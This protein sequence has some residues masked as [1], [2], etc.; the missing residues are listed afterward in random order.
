[1]PESGIV[2]Q[3]TCGAYRLLT[4]A[5]EAGPRAPVRALPMSLNQGQLFHL[6]TVAGRNGYAW[7]AAMAPLGGRTI[8]L[9]CRLVIVGT[10]STG[11]RLVN[12]V[13]CRKIAAGVELAHR[14]G[15]LGQFGDYS[16]RRAG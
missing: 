10:I 11:D 9:G 3:R 5:Y 15:N 2:R 7:G 14:N 1:M 13:L 4:V 8:L 16:G 12:T 6:N